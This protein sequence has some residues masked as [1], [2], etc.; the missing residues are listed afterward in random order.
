MLL[1]FPFTLLFTLQAPAGP[2]AAVTF[3]YGSSDALDGLIVQ[4]LEESLIDWDGFCKFFAN[5]TVAVGGE[6]KKI[7]LN[8]KPQGKNN[9]K[10][11]NSEN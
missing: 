2:D 5:E 4:R 11:R 1:L 10:R 3:L 8:G 9:C 7:F 6:G